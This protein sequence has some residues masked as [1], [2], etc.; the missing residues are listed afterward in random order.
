MTT[1]FTDVIVELFG[2]SAQEGFC[3]LSGTLNTRSFGFTVWTGINH[4]QLL[5]DHLYLLD[6]VCY[7]KK[8][9]PLPIVQLLP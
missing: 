1:I 3:T 5:F 7:K 8:D 9:R 4:F 2:Q 6:T